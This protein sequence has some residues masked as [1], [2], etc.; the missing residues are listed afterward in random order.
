MQQIDK[1]NQHS[2]KE[3]CMVL[4]NVL[5]FQHQQSVNVNFVLLL[6]HVNGIVPLVNPSKFAP[7]SPVDLVQ[8]KKL[9]E[10]LVFFSV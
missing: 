1:G 3:E 5:S 10:F 6:D 2:S 4:G 7:D 8:V 9:S